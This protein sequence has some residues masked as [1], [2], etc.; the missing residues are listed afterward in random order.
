MNT[1]AST[2]GLES[3]LLKVAVI[4]FFIGCAPL[5]ALASGPVIRS[6]ETVGVEAN[7]VLEGDF[8][9]LG[10]TVTI[11]G[12]ASRDVYALGGAVTTN[13]PVEEDLVIIGGVV[14]V[15]GEVKD[16]I[17][18]VGGEVVIAE[19]VADDV[20]VVGGTV[21]ILSTATI[22]GDLIF[23]GG[24]IRIDGPVSGA[25][26]GTGNTVRIDALV[27]G[28][29]SVRAAESFT[30]GDNADVKGSMSYKSDTELVRAQGAV[31]TGTITRD[32]LFKEENTKNG[33]EPLVL[34]VLI[35][36]FS[37][38]TV[39]FLVK[40]RINP[41]VNTIFASYGKLGLIGLGMFVVLPIVS[42][43][44]MASV[45]G[46][47]VGVALLLSYIVLIA[48]AFITLPIIIGAL[49]QRLARLGDSVTLFTVIIGVFVTLLIPFI[50][51][52]GGF[53]LFLGFV[54]TVGALCSEL[55]R[56]FK[57]S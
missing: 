28:D 55:Y 17:R 8:Y 51:I 13:A 42:I 12:A 32:S 19:P 36:I 10:Q 43:I 41:F 34:N 14:Q 50:P 11:S 6:G 3:G 54:V 1:M 24:E 20:V 57:V 46:L 38:L 22:G 4:T 23:F 30:L 33:F 39:F 37:S 15:H 45:I 2:H 52:I 21:H 29:V 7:Q 9:G 47:I 35:L 18:I 16:D 25:V 31:V 27:G 40:S 5:L 44:L 48:V 53:A 49:V 26:Y 56:F